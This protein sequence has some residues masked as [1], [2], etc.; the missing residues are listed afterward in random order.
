M[1]R[2]SSLGEILLQ[3]EENSRATERLIKLKVSGM[4][5]ENVCHTIFRSADFLASLHRNN[6]ECFPKIF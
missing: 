6:V 5:N 3:K 2:R 4:A 1:K